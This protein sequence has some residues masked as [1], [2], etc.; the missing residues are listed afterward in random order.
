MSK[1]LKS[2]YRLNSLIAI[3]VFFVYNT[4]SQTGDSQILSGLLL[5]MSMLSLYDV[6]K[7]RNNEN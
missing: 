6:I 1:Y 4:I 5:P 7:R 3:N 2:K